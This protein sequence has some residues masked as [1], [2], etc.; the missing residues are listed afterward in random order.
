M[1]ASELIAAFRA[2]YGADARIFCAPGRVNLIGKHT[3]HSAGFGG[4]TVSLMEGS[5]AES[6]CMAVSRRY[7]TA[8]GIDPDISPA[9]ASGGAR[10]IKKIRPRKTRTKR[11]SSL[12]IPSCAAPDGIRNPH[13]THGVW[14]PEARSFNW[15]LET[16]NWEPNFLNG[17]AKRFSEQ[18]SITRTVIF[19]VFRGQILQALPYLRFFL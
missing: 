2:R 9:R 10:E 3:D 15:K 12:E 6:F 14:R 11:L 19:R 13:A 7:R 16:G 8:T 5:R 4:C 17:S 1:D 18:A